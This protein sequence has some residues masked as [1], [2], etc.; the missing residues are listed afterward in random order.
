MDITENELNEKM[1]SHKFT[2]SLL[3]LMVKIRSRRV[4]EQRVA[5][6]TMITNAKKNLSTVYKDGM[7]EKH[8]LVYLCKIQFFFLE[9]ISNSNEIKV[10]R[11]E[12]GS[13]AVQSALEFR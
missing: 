5:E 9:I 6:E 8:L 7:T 2:S 13:L 10:G 1:Q 12:Y 4:H 11:Y 3:Y